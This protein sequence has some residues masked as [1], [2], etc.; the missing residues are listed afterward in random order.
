MQVALAAEVTDSVGRDRDQRGRQVRL[1]YRSG[2][3]ELH[4]STTASPV[5]LERPRRRGTT[6]PSC[7]VA[8]G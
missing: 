5:T 3:G 6:E 7:L 2:H 1:G 8:T 4:A